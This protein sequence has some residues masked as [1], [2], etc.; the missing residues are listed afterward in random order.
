MSAYSVPKTA[1]SFDFVECM[2]GRD[3]YIE[4]MLCHHR[5]LGKI[6]PTMKMEG[7]VAAFDG[8][9]RRT[10]RPANLKSE[11]WR[12]AHGPEFAEVR[13]AQRRAE[14]VK[15]AVDNKWKPG[16]APSDVARRISRNR[17]LAATE[18]FTKEEHQKRRELSLIHI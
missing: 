1:T 9:R 4:R 11:A 15:A 2:G 6:Q 17:R 12:R 18:R 16:S 13:E 7:P 10:P 8:G 5:K 3:R 14:K